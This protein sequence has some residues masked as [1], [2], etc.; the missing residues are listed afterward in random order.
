MDNLIKAW[1]S[2]GH[3][4]TEI[5]RRLVD[6]FFVA[7]L[8]DAGAGDVWKFTEPESG[9]TYGR[10]EGIAVAALYMFKAG[11]FSGS[12]K[13][14]NSE[15]VNGK[16]IILC[17]SYEANH[18]RSGHGLLSLD[19]AVFR[20]HFQISSGNE[21]IGDTSRLSLLKSVGESLL[22]LPEIFGD[23]GRPGN[24]VGKSEFHSCQWSLLILHYRLFV[25]K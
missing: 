2:A 7:V 25:G 13:G 6:L 11:I 16:L 8:L 21:I 5:T 17:K 12:G 4:E 18:L 20:E 15:S 24:L 22:N 1:Q 9:N 10:S 23:S 3:D 19:I 14:N